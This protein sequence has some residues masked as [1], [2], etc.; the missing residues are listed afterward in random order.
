[1][2]WVIL[3]PG[4]YDLGDFLID[5]HCTENFGQVVAKVVPRISP[6][7]ED[8]AA[9][10]RSVA[11]PFG[12]ELL[13]SGLGSSSS[14]LLEEAGGRSPPRCRWANPLSSPRPRPAPVKV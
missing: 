9:P 8:K 3:S 1:M 2:C 11:S 12:C 5:P 6:V 14:S 13:G 10:A 7:Q 4:E